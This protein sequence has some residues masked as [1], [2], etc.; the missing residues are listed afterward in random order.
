M[1][2]RDRDSKKINTTITKQSENRSD[3]E[4]SRGP[5]NRRYS[6]DCSLHLS[7]Q[8]SAI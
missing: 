8:Y 6:M 2:E 7:D 1:R 4:A 5:V 3:N